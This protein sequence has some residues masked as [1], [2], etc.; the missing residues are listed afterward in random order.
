MQHRLKLTLAHAKIL[1]DL[2]KMAIDLTPAAIGPFVC[3]A[4]KLIENLRF[5][6]CQYDY[7]RRTSDD[8]YRSCN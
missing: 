1:K 2:G 4:V 8:S 3:P 7:V 6:K 5:R